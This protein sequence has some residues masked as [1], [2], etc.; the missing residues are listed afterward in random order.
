MKIKA[1]TSFCG[2]ISMTEGDIRECS[3]ETALADLLRAGYVQEV[4]EGSPEKDAN[5][6]SDPA[7]EDGTAQEAPQQGEA[8]AEK[9]SRRKKNQNESQ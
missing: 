3:N 8:P 7:P 6:V 4:L 9:K 2:A 1:L 5:P